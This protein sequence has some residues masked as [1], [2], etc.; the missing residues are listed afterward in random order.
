MKGGS[1][2]RKGRGHLFLNREEDEEDAPPPCHDVR[3]TGTNGAILFS[4]E[5]G[6]R[7]PAF[8]DE[9]EAVFLRKGRGSFFRLR[10]GKG[11]DDKDAPRLLRHDVPLQGEEQ[12]HFVSK[13]SWRK[14][15]RI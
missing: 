2:L 1:F 7:P 10:Q 13:G 12:A 5:T 4:K 3:L 15:I 8:E 6:G 9:G 14:P 11:Q